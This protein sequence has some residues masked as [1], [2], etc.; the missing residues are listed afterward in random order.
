MLPRYIEEAWLL[1]HGKQTTV[2]GWGSNSPPVCRGRE[3]T[4]EK[5][6]GSSDFEGMIVTG[7]RKT[8]SST[9]SENNQQ[10]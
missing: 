4:V 8:S 10:V 6:M 5:K 1:D 7:F 2:A 3:K 9:F